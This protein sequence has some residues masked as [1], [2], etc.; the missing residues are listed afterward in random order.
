VGQSV[1]VFGHPGI[2]GCFQPDEVVIDL[3]E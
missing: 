1:E 2:G 3:T